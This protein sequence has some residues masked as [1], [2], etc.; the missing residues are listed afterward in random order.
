MGIKFS[1]LVL[2]L[3]AQLKLDSELIKR[4]AKQGLD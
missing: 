3:A 4:L 1:V 2:F